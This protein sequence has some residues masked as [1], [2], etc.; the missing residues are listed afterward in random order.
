ML[1]RTVLFVKLFACILFFTQNIFANIEI[2]TKDFNGQIDDNIK[3]YH[4]D[5]KTTNLYYLNSSLKRQ[6]FDRNE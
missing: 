6:P 2:I 1:S 5:H 4:Y 3:S